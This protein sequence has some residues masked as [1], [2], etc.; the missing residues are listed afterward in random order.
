MSN[1][2]YARGAAQNRK[3]NFAQAIEDYNM[4]LEKDSERTSA[5]SI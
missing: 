1:A 2:A 3:G 4:A 5:A